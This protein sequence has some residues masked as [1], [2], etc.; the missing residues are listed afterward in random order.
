M[1]NALPWECENV[2]LVLQFFPNA[3]VYKVGKLREWT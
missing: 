1:A 2:K 3:I